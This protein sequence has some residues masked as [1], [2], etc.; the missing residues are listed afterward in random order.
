ML[1]NLHSE[2][3]NNEI[4]RT[5]LKNLH[6]YFRKIRDIEGTTDYFRK[7][8]VNA[9]IYKFNVGR[10]LEDFTQPTNWRIVC[11]IILNCLK[12]IQVRVVKLG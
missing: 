7:D 2:P 8:F 6:N 3:R 11:F 4:L 5:A 10:F 1:Q 9:I 12:I